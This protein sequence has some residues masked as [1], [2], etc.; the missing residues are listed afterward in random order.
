MVIA[1]VCF[2]A[3]SLRNCGGGRRRVK[4]ISRIQLRR[5][6]TNLKAF[7]RFLAARPGIFCQHNPVCGEL[8]ILA[9]RDDGVQTC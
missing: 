3:G 9:E 1:D 2:S 5:P 6:A 7:S 8:L 4:S